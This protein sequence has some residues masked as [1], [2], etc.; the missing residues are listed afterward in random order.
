MPLLCRYCSPRA[1]SR[2]RWILT[3][4]DRYRSLSNSC[5][6]FPPFMYCMER[7]RTNRSDRKTSQDFRC[8]Q[9][10]SV[11]K[12]RCWVHRTFLQR[13]VFKNADSHTHQLTHI[14]QLQSKENLTH[15]HWRF[16]SHTRTH[17]AYSAA[18]DTFHTLSFFTFTCG[19][20]LETVSKNAQNTHTTLCTF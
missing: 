13:N 2:D 16:T 15:T 5:S 20:F 18:W 3:P 7:G 8:S 4:H 19:G 12:K 10:F 17:T 14:Q 1:I 9:L 6:R 11:N